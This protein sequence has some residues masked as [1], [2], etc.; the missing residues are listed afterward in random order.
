[1]APRNVFPPAFMSQLLSNIYQDKNLRDVFASSLPL[2]GRSGSLRNS[3]KGTV[4]E[5]NLRA[6]SGSLE[7]VRAYSGYVSNRNGRMLAFSILLNNY[8]C[9]GG[10]ARKKLLQLMAQLAQSG[11]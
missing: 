2:A 1:M 4:A 6:K 5:G 10:P 11:N 7:Q 8:E 9:G 3:L